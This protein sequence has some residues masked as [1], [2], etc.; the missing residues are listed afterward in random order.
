MEYGLI[1]M[2]NC[3]LEEGKI[4]AE[5]YSITFAD[6]SIHDI[7]GAVINGGNFERMVTHVEK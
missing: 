3:M 6:N 5:S 1:N 4:Q 7:T 2:T